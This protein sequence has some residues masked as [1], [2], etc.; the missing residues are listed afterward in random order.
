MMLENR[1]SLIVVHGEYGIRAS[2]AVRCK[3]TVRRQRSDDRMTLRPE[4]RTYRLDHLDFFTTEVSA[5][6]GMGIEAC[7]QHPRIFESESTPEIGEQDVQAPFEQLRGDGAR[8][9]GQRQMRRRQC[10]SERIRHQQ[11]HHILDTCPFTEK[12]GMATEWRAGFVDHRFLYGPRYQRL[13]GPFQAGSGR[14]TERFDHVCGVGRIRHSGSL[15]NGK[16]DGT[17]GQ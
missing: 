7:H 17:D 3:Q 11:H 16:R 8:H 5:L 4:C 10:D 15:R 12:L 1:Q 6:T 9:F 14:L 13:S 2:E